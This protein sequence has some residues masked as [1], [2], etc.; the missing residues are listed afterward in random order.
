[1][2]TPKQLKLTQDME[3][4][5][6]KL[7][8]LMAEAKKEK[9]FIVD[10]APELPQ[11]LLDACRLV[12]NRHDMI[13]LLPKNGVIAEIGTDRGAFAREMLAKCTPQTLHIFEL[14]ISRIHA[15]NI[16]TEL[17]AGQVEIHEGDSFEN[18]S[19]MPDGTF[20]W[21]CIDGDRSYEGVLRDITASLPKL[22]EGGLLVS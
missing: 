3:D 9:V 6:R 13:D 4:A 22:R 12:R 7:A 17:Q 8:G 16:D 2:R 10:R 11:A 21:I 20:D 18:T 14:D 1:M 5:R 19:A 15:P